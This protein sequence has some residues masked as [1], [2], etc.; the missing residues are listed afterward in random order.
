MYTKRVKSGLAVLEQHLK[1]MDGNLCRAKANSRNDFVEQAIL[2]WKPELA[3]PINF[4]NHPYSRHRLGK[5]FP[6]SMMLR[7]RRTAKAQ[8][9]TVKCI[10]A[11]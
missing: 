5:Y 11:E 8:R 6:I 10:L 9:S 7:L 1:R 4:L 3:V 2:F